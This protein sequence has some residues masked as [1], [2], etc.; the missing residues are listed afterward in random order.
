MEPTRRAAAIGLIFCVA[1][2]FLA[3][4]RVN[5]MNRRTPEEAVYVNHADMAIL[6]S[7]LLFSHGQQTERD[8][9]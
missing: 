9:P 1:G 2:L 4:Y 3:P 6:G 8:R 5:T 7:Q